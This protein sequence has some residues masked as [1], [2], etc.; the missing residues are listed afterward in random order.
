MPLPKTG[1]RPPIDADAPATVETA[2]FA[3][4]CFWCPDAQFGILPGIVR[5]RV[6]YAGGTTPNPT[7]HRIGDHTECVQV[8]YDP[9]RL[10]YE[11][12]LDLI[13]KSHNPCQG[14]GIRQYQHAIFYESE[15]QRKAIEASRERLEETLGKPVKTQILPLTGFTPAE[16]Y[17]QKYE[18]RCTEGL[19]EEFRAIYPDPK[20]LCDS[21][22]A[23]RVNGYIAGRGTRAQLDVEAPRLGLSDEGLRRLR[24]YV[25]K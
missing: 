10:S 2:T 5:T 4:G 14:T 17:H 18:L 8:D 6:G 13:W 1:S 25:T 19:I 15:A 24:V 9:A 11:Q 23:A 22:A 20:D 3:M 16:D 21:T 7:Y 12:V